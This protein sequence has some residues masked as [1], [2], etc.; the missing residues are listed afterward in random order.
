MRSSL[1]QC[2]LQVWWYAGLACLA[3][4]L[5]C[6]SGAGEQPVV[7]GIPAECT[8][9]DS[10]VPVALAAEAYVIAYDEYEGRPAGSLTRSVLSDGRDVYWYDE[11]G[12]V[13]VER[14]ADGRVVELQR[15]EPSSGREYEAALG[16]AANA[17]RVFV[18]YG[19]RLAGNDMPEIFS[20]GRLL[21]LAKED[22]QSEVLLSLPGQWIAPVLADAERVIVFAPGSDGG[23]FY[24][25][26]L[27]APRLEPLPLGRAASPVT[28]AGYEWD[29]WAL[30]RQGQLVGEDVYWA[31]PASPSRRLRRASFDATE[32]ELVTQVSEHYS[33]GPGYLLTQEDVWS[34]GYYYAGKAFLLRDD[35]GCRSVRGWPGRPASDVVLDSQ[36]VYWIDPG[37]AQF[38]ADRYQVMRLDRVSGALAYLTF[39][40]FMPAEYLRL[41]GHDETRLFLRMSGALVSVRKP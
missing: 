29:A 34:P 20:P 30:F 37:G 28:A 26:P 38:A 14:Q 33:V 5:A 16:L 10:S 32:G 31:P 12:T 1:K 27:A 39:P 4:G 24:Q 2:S 6:G 13:F 36:F 22:G 19:H 40:A 9:L 21:S 11:L 23:G 18:G 3:P 8:V 15:A 7:R 17:E 41:V 35:S 25:V